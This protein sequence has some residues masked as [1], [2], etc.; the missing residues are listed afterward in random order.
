[1]A[2]SHG[3]CF[4]RPR[5][6]SPRRLRTSAGE[7]VHRRRERRSWLPEAEFKD[8]TADAV[9]DLPSAFQDLKPPSDNSVRSWRRVTRSPALVRS[10]RGEPE[11]GRSK[12]RPGLSAVGSSPYGRLRPCF[13]LVVLFQTASLRAV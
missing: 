10:R 11:G 9:P 12:Q 8:H 3:L 2:E 6:G 4:E 5:S 1:M 13:D 7:R